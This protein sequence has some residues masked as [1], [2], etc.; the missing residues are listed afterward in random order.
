MVPAAGREDDRRAVGDEHD[1]RV[2]VLV[3]GLPRMTGELL[4]ALL[5]RDPLAIVHRQAGDDGE[6]GRE[7]DRLG[8]RVLIVGAG[9]LRAAH[10]ELE[11]HPGLKVLM[12]AGDGG[13]SELHEFVPHRRRLGGISA[14][15]LERALRDAAAWPPA[16]ERV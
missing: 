13:R 12:V 9:R 10:A 1:N 2:P 4:E 3:T 15:I 8:I 11:S 14:D 5:D 16:W 6:L 7:I